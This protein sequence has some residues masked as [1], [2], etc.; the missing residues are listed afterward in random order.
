MKNNKKKQ[1]ETKKLVKN[2]DGTYD[3]QIIVQGKVVF[4]KH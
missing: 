2:G 3:L 4:L 1:K